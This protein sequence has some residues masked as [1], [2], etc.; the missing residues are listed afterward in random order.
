MDDAPGGPLES[1]A[2][3][4]AFPDQA[5]EVMVASLD[6]ESR[7]LTLREATTCPNGDIAFGKESIV[8]LTT[9]VG[10]DLSDD[11]I[12]IK[13]RSGKLLL[14]L[15]IESEQDQQAWVE[16]I[17]GVI[18][19]NLSQ[20]GAAG[21]GRDDSDEDE[22]SMWRA[23]SQRLQTRIG[24]L[25]ARG[26]RHDD[27]L[28]KMLGRIDGAMEM[29]GAVQDMCQQQKQVIVAQHVAIEELERDCAAA[30]VA[31]PA[32]A[33]PSAAAAAAAPAPP[34]ARAAPAPQSRPPPGGG[35]ADGGDEGDAN[36]EEMMALLKKADEMQR[37]LE[38][39]EAMGVSAEDDG[40]EEASGAGQPQG[41][42]LGGD[43]DDQEGLL[44]RLT[45]MRSLM[46][47][48]EAEVG[49]AGRAA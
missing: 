8:R 47:M 11:M 44:R 23:R 30:G 12:G 27:Q 5:P 41:D 39:L 49:A 6:V 33:R 21:G 16:G 43:Q 3:V 1:T 26:Q 19:V 45:D 4:A 17:R 34:A 2:L 15:H 9:A 36:L 24:T 38:A 18:E 22:L 31:I 32:P 25:Q 10:I 14:Q 29:L 28:R 46:S 37:A 40:E 13:C 20:G 48:L 7:A 35:G 42:A